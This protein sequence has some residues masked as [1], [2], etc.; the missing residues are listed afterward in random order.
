VD[1]F[2]DGSDTLV[3]RALAGAPRERA[4]RRVVERHVIPRLALQAPALQRPERF[5]DGL[6]EE[7]AGFTRMALR[8][9]G[10]R[11]RRALHR[12]FEA[13]ASFTQLQLGLLAPAA[14]RLDR[15]WRDDEV[16]FIDVTLAV[17]NLQQMMR[18]V[19][20]DLAQTGHL[21]P[22]PFAILL[23]PAPGDAHGFGAAMAAEFFRRDGWS[24]ALEPHPT[25]A[26]LAARVAG[27]WTDV[28][29]LSAVCRPDT[30]ALAAVVA[31]V[32]AASANPDL[33]VI[34][35]GEAVAADPAL[36]AAIGA[37][38]ALAALDAAPAR[39]HRLVSAL[40]GARL[41]ATG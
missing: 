29:G 41:A 22:A 20:L 6:S 31:Q 25:A 35:G 38:A 7:V 19:A 13:G 39:A 14:K 32:R 28:L 24:V 5:G 12:L 3:S 37:D 4:L 9:D 23:A 10:D 18:F 16:S 21:A 33:L 1:E 34:V 15:M 27:G 8:S 30:T 2:V 40:F 17:G 11:S 36:V 26:G